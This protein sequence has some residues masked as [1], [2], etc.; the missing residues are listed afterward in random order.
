MVMHG[1]GHVR[2]VYY[3]GSKGVTYGMGSHEVAYDLGSLFWQ[4]R[5]YGLGLGSEG[6]VRKVVGY[7]CLQGSSSRSTYV[8]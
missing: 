6:V 8:E 4:G 3:L 7:R 1:L 5:M 2:V